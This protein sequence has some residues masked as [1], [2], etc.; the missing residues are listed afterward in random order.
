MHLRQ[1]VTWSDGTPFTAA[2]V[3]FSVRA[4]FDPKSGSVVGSGLMPGGSPI[5]AE[6]PDSH[7][8][9]LSYAAA[10]G[11]GIGLLDM[12]PI[13]PKHSLEGA[14]DAGTFAKVWD[15]SVTPAA[16]AGTGPFVLRENQT[17]QRIILERNPRY[18]RKAAGGAQLPYLDRIVLEIV[19]EQNAELLRLQ[20]GETDLSYAELRPEDYVPVRRAEENGVLKMVEAGV[21]TARGRLESSTL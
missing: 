16:L 7:T 3:L 12:L 2:D 19:P 21:S 11:P 15:A 18:W 5:R 17:G 10:S 20:S 1:G 14:L 8:V 9:V 6:A 4:A 13:L